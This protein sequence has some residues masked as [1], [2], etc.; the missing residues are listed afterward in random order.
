M[1]DPNQLNPPVVMAALLKEAKSLGFRLFSELLTGSLLRT[2]AA[3]KPG[4][5]LL[6]LGTGVGVGIAWLL[7]GLSP[8]ASLLTVDGDPRV[9]EV[10]QRHLGADPRVHFHLGDAAPLLGQLPAGSFDLIFAD[11]LP[12]KFSHLTEALRLLRVGGLYVV[13]DLRPQPTWPK[14]HA[15]NVERLMGELQAR[16]ELTLTRLDWSTG[17]VIAVRRG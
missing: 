3:T 2:L 9:Q 4:G 10:A 12:G 17:I 5:R 15:A 1:H 13:D 16:E 11:A 8:G 6:E 14:D 7:D